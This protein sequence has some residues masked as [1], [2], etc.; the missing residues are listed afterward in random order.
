MK[1][2]SRATI[3]LLRRATGQKKKRKN[4]ADLQRSTRITHF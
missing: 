1:P 2:P 4:L 3:D